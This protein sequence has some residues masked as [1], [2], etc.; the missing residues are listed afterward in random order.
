MLVDRRAARDRARLQR[1]QLRPAGA[2]RRRGRRATA[3]S[4][5]A[6][7]EDAWFEDARGERVTAIAQGEP[8]HDRAWRSRF[9]EPIEEPDLRARRC[10][11]RSRHT[12]FATSTRLAA[13]SDRAA[14]RPARRSRCASSFENWLAPSR[15]TLTPVGRARRR[16]RRRARPARGPRVAARPRHARDRRHRRRPARRSRSSGRERASPSASARRARATTPRRF[17]SLTW[18]LAVTDWKLRFYGSVL[19]YVWTLVR[20]FAFFGVICFV[21]TEI[22]ELGDDVKNYG[23]YILFA[24]V[25][26]QFFAEVDRQLRARRSSTRENL[27]RKMRFPRLVIPLSVALDGA[28]QPRHD[29]GRRVHLR[30]RHRRL[31]DVG[32]A[33]ADPADRAADG[34]RDRRRDAAQRRCS[35]ATATC[36]RS[37]TSSRRCCST[38]RRSCT[39]RRWCRRSTSA[40]YLANPIAAVLTA[41]APR[42]R[43]PDGARAPPRRS[44]ARPRLLIPLGDRRSS[45]FVARRLGVQPRGA[46]DRRE[47]VSRARRRRP[48]EPSSRR[49]ARGWR[50]LEARARRAVAARA[51]A[52]VAAAQERVYWLDRWHLDLNAL[53][54]PPRRGRVP[55]RR[56]AARA[57]SSGASGCSSAASLG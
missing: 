27:L 30:D 6:E 46:A 3:T 40:P 51:N 44:A 22:A 5:A 35:S 48:S 24:L 19:G 20:P 49:C 23:V 56:C 17:W 15:Y 57:A 55:R 21:F 18:T 45:S 11:T 33:R 14:S 42:G 12:V 29:A 37:G 50:E 13:T 54:A 32:L 31:P 28:V 38:P 7:I 34:V 4:A 43:R 2:R 41:D 16:R 1:A 9:H 52:A 36:S 10:A 53:M 8:L 25:L 47:P 26:F 39:S